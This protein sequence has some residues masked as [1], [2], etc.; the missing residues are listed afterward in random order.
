MPDRLAAAAV[1]FLADYFEN[2]ELQSSQ[3]IR[4]ARVLS[5]LPD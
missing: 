5:E 4:P 1:E 2:V 3:A